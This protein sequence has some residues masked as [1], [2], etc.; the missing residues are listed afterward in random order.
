MAK[1]TLL[2]GCAAAAQGGKICGS[3]SH[4]FFPIRPYT[5]IMMELARMV[6]NGELDAEFVHGEG[7]HAQVSVVLGA[8][9]AERGPTPEAPASG[10]LMPLRFIAL[11]RVAVIL[12]RWPLRTGPLILREISVPNIPTPCLPGIRAG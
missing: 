7:E 1:E 5:A 10:S 9:A 2:S 3:G 11:R 4:L 12:C 6:A 8:S